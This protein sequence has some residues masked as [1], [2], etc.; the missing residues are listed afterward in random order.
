M[1]ID[2]KA[3]IQA[4]KQYIRTHPAVGEPQELPKN[5]EESSDEYMAR[6]MA[7]IKTLRDET[8]AE[9]K[10]N[11]THLSQP[12]KIQRQLTLV[13]DDYIYKFRR[14][15]PTPSVYQNENYH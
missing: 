11:T 4:L 1:P 2:Y 15:P 13:I 7:Y 9:L 6:L 3:Y 12:T 14:K 8:E 5:P 10:N